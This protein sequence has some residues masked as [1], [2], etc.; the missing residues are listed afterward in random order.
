MIIPDSTILIFD[1]RHSYAIKIDLVILKTIARLCM[2]DSYLHLSQ[3]MQF[4]LLS[5]EE[6]DI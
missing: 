4:G 3:S 2:T 1:P 5:V 6:F